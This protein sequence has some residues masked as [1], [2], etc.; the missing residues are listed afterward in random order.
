MLRKRVHFKGEMERY[1]YLDLL[2]E[3]GFL[4][5]SSIADNGAF[6][7]VEA[8]Y[9]GTPCACS[10]YPH[11]RFMAECFNLD[12]LF[13]KGSSI[14]SIFE[15]FKIMGSGSFNGRI[16]SCEDLRKMN[17]ANQSEAVKQTLKEAW[18]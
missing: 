2:S 13:Y 15:T 14:N 10:D 17:Y 4:F 18:I 11:M 12:V 5:L 3:A 6:G 7:A 9:L 16:P 1:D 8:A